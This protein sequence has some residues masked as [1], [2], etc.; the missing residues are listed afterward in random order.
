MGIV[1]GHPGKHGEMTKEQGG[2]EGMRRYE[3][4][5]WKNFNLMWC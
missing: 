2:D 4:S 3:S 1:R 5:S